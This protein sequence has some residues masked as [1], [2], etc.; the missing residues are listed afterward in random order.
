MEPVTLLSGLVIPGRLHELG[1]D[2]ALEQ[3]LA[4]GRLGV[5][6]GGGHPGGEA[7]RLE[8]PEQPEQ[9]PL[10]LAAAPVAEGDARPDLQ[11]PGLELVQPAALVR[12]PAGEHRQ[13]PV[14]PALEP[15]SGDPD[16]QGQEPAQPRNRLGRVRLGGDPRRSGQL[17]QQRHGLVGLEHVQ[18]ERMGR[19]QSGQVD[20]AGDQRRA[21]PAARQQR[22]HLRFAGR[23]VEHDQRPGVGQAGPELAGPLVQT[24]RDH[25]A[26]DPKRAQEAGQ[27]VGRVQRLGLGAAQVHVQLPVGEPWPQPVGDPDGQGGLAD[28]GLAGDRRDDDRGRLVVGE[29]RLQLGQGTFPTGEVVDVGGELARPRRRRRSRR[30]PGSRKGR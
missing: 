8:Q 6:Q 14:G 22:P 3:L 10:V 26:L 13:A 15:G 1:V 24:L 23:V 19:L 4:L 9:P 17:G 12:E 27:H 28:P 29:Q 30:V 5:E 11:V 16:C 20:P 18:G 2:Q 21:A 25:R 7:G